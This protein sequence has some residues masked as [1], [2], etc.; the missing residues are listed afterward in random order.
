[1]LSLYKDPSGES[2]FTENTAAINAFVSQLGMAGES[3]V[4]ALKKKIKELQE[5]IDKSKVPQPS[6]SICIICGS[7]RYRN[8][9]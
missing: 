5:A 9:T 8:Q 7:H 2:I 6:C 1:M 4:E 3:E